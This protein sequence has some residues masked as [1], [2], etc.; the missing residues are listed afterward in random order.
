METSTKYEVTIAEKKNGDIGDGTGLKDSSSSENS[1]GNRVMTFK[2]STVFI[3]A[4]SA[5]KNGVNFIRSN[6]V[7]MTGDNVTQQKTTSISNIVELAGSIGAAF[8]GGGV[9]GGS[10]AVI[11]IATN[12][13]LKAGQRQ[14]EINNRNTQ[15]AVFKE[16]IG[17]VISG[18]GR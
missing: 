6:Y 3:A 9:I 15:T 13:G 17:K 1:I 11:A 12:L 4:Y 14:I 10:A 8:A 2:K 16:R 5:V 7:N 18:G